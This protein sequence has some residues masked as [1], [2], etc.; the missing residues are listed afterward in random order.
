MIVKSVTPRRAGGRETPD[1]ILESD[2]AWDAAPA[3]KA[4]RARNGQEFDSA[5]SPPISIE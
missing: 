3:L 2:A 5:L 4:G 1:L